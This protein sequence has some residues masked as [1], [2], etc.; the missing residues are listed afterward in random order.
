[1]L[2]GYFFSGDVTRSS[3]VLYHEYGIQD[4]NLVPKF[5]FVLLTLPLPV[6][7]TH[8]LLPIGTFSKETFQD[9]DGARK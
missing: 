8:A 1:M 4:G 9:G 6:F 7:T 5:S 2:S 3:P